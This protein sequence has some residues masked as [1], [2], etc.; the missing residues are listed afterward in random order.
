MSNQEPDTTVKCRCGKQVDGYRASDGGWR[1][2]HRVT[3][4]IFCG[5]QRRTQIAAPMHDFD[6]HET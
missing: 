6:D 5:G 3:G 2:R 1:W 4:S